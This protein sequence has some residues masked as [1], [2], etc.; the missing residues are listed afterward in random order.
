MSNELIYSGEQKVFFKEVKEGK[1]HIAVNANPGSGK[2]SSSLIALN[3]IPKFK[4]VIFVSFS[5]MIVN[6][7]KERV[8]AHV[9][10]TTL[11]S[12]G[13]SIVARHRNGVK[14]NNNKYFQA[15]MVKLKYNEAKLAKD[16]DGEKK[17][18]QVLKQAYNIQDI[19]NYARNTLTN[20]MPI[21]L[22]Q[23]CKHYELEYDTKTINLVIELIEKGKKSN[24]IDFADMIYLP[25]IYPE[26]IDECY[27]YLI[28]D[29]VQ[30][31]NN[32]QIEFVK[33]LIH[34]RGRFIL[35]GDERQSIFSF[36]GSSID[37]FN[38]A[39]KAL[40]G[41]NL[42]RFPLSTTYRCGRRIVEEINKVYDVV[43]PWDNAE[44]GIVRDGFWEEI[45]ETDL[46]LCRNNAPLLSLYFQLIRI[47]TK[48]KIIG[49]EIEQGLHSLA[50][51]CMAPTKESFFLNLENR[52]D[53]LEEQLR[54]RGVNKPKG[55]PLFRALY[56]KCDM[57]VMILDQVVM[58]YELIDKIHSIFSDEDEDGNKRIGARLSSI[59]KAKG[60]ENDRVFLLTHYNSKRLLPSEHATSDWQ[61]KQEKNLEFVAVSRAKK[62]LVYFRYDDE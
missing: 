26:M 35:V 41:N 55:H 10:A 48:A 16:K 11:H 43:R 2:T 34:E 24:V 45:N 54:Q 32:A 20:L 49:R 9:K 38:I 52:L 59:H 12:L 42:S 61:I 40:G 58:P 3:Y 51:S 57:V 21:D 62:E 44:E 14:L 39:C 5:N 56:E 15:A 13:F 28:Y 7:L 27:D 53:Q 17:R 8:P 4:K 60:S 25:A 30:D 50:Q 22:V 46:V 6:E 47:G 29:E 31:A 23:M 1:G 37:S 33:H 19:C 18:K 36:T